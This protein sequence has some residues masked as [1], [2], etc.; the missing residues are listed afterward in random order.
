MRRKHST[1]LEVLLSVVFLVCI[2][3]VA[4]STHQRMVHAT[5]EA[6]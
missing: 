2:G 1:A 4:M 3:L 6:R 5:E